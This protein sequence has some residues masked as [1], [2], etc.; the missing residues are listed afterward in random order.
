[1][2]KFQNVCWKTHNEGCYYTSCIWMIVKNIVPLYI[3]KI[4]GE[5]F[6]DAEDDSDSGLETKDTVILKYSWKERNCIV[7]CVLMVIV[8]KLY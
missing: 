4:W 6:H 1:M 2:E 5:S 3:K 8:I 7:V